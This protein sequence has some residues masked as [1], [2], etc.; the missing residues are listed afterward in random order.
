MCSLHLALQVKV[1]KADM[2]LLIEQLHETLHVLAADKVPTIK[3]EKRLE[4][5]SHK[6]DDIKKL[7]PQVKSNVEPIQVC[8]HC[9]PAGR[10]TSI[11]VQLLPNR[12]AWLQRS[13]CIEKTS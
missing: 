10:C 2:D 1:K 13:Q 12:L 6:W 9:P 5:A 4:E 11:M 7:Q 3:L 8:L